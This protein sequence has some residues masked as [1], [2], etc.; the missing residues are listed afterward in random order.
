MPS[1]EVCPRKEDH[2]CQLR[3]HHSYIHQTMTNRVTG[4][5]Q[6]L[7]NFF[8][9][10]PRHP[11]TITHTPRPFR[12]IQSRRT[13]VPT[14][15]FRMTSPSSRLHFLQYWNIAVTSALTKYPTC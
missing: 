3:M 15:A 7:P 2:R 10:P 11:R 8:N 9:L 13:F 6:N 4:L 12:S 14:S 5:R 1:R